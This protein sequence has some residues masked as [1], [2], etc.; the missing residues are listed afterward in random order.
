M[1]QKNTFYLATAL[2]IGLFAFKIADSTLFEFAYPKRNGTTF[3]LASSR[4]KKF[5]KEWR[6]TD[7]YYYAEQDGFICSVL[8]YK[9]N[10]DEKLQ[11]V[12]ALKV[13]IGGPDISSAY[14]FAY[15]SNYSK[16]KAMERNNE[17]WGAPTDDF[18]YRQNNVVM[19]GA[20]FAQKNMY[21]YAM[22]GKDLF[23]NVHLSKVACSSADSVEMRA[24]LTSLTV[25]K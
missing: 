25:K 19:D 14:P 15:F 7:Y 5:K 17:D 13:A 18:M 24:I 8:Y 4:F 9:L 16:L 10:D 21:G 11:L 1:K 2:V 6:G 23:V 20:N 3:T 12:D 22:L